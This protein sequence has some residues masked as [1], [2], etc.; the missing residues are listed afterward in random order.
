[1]PDFVTAAL[2]SSSCWLI[3]ITLLVCAQAPLA[4][5]APPATFTADVSRSTSDKVTVDFTLVPIRHSN[6]EVRLVQSD[7]SL[8]PHT[9]LAPRTYLG[10]VRG[11]PGA[12]ACGWLRPDGTLL[13]RVA[14][15]DGNEWS[16]T[17]G[18][19]SVRGPTS[20]W[21]A[22][23]TTVVPA[24]G[25]GGI[26]YAAET[27]VDLPYRQLVASGGTPDLAVGMAEYAVMSANYLFLRDAAIL[28]RVGRVVIR[29]AE[30]NDPY[31]AASSVTTTTLLNEVKNQ[32]NNVL[33]A[34][35]GH[36]V[37]L[38]ARPSVNGGLAWVG[39]IGNSSNRY[40]S[41]N[42]SSI[43]D[44]SVVWRHEVGHNWGSNHYEGGGRPEGPTIMSD[45]SL[46]RFSSS[47]LEKMIAHRNARLSFLESTSDYPFPLPP[48]ANMDRAMFAPEGGTSIDVL[49]NDSDSNGDAISLL[50]F[51]AECSRGGVITRLVGAGPDGRDLLHYT[52]DPE[53]QNGTAFFR[54]RISDSTG[55]TGT[56]YVMVRPE[57]DTF[58]PLHH[59]TLD[60]TSGSTAFNASS[61]PSGT[62]VRNPS[63]GV[64]GATAVTGRGVTY[65]GS[66]QSTSIPALN[67]TGNSYT[68]TAWIRRS[69]SQ[70][71][72]APILYTRNSDAS[73]DSYTGLYLSSNQLRVRWNGALFTPSPALSVPDGEWCLVAFSVS[74]SQVLLHLRTAA[75][76]STSTHNTTIASAS[77]SNPLLL[78]RTQPSSGS[79]LYFGG[80]I[81][82]VRNFP[83]ALGAV[84]VGT[85]YSQAAVPPVFAITNPEPNQLVNPE[86]TRFI[87]AATPPSSLLR[88]V[89][90]YDLSSSQSHGTVHA[91]PFALALESLDPGPQLLGARA[92]YGDW[93]YQVEATP[94]P[95]LV[96]EAQRP[97]VTLT[98]SGHPS[99][100]GP[101]TRFVFRRDSSQGTLELPFSL[102]G[103]A[104]RNTDFTLPGNSVV[105]ANGQNE[106]AIQLTPASEPSSPGEKSLTLALTQTA[107]FVIESPSSATVVFADS[108][109]SVASGN[110]SLGSVW[111]NA[112]A[113]PPAGTQG[114]G[115][116]YI[117]M[118][119]HVV[120][121]FDEASNAQAMVS[122]A[123]RITNTGR[124][125][126]AR[127]HATTLQNVSY[128]V[129]RISL[130][131]GGTLRFV[132]SIGSSGHQLAAAIEAVGNATL[133]FSGGAYDQFANLSGPISGTGNLA[134][135]SLS[136]AGSVVANVR[137]FSILSAGNPFSGDWSIEHSPSGDDFAAL[138]AAAV[139][140]LGS[141]GVSVKRRSRLI[142]DH[143]G[144]LDSLAFIR[145][146]GETSSLLLNQP[147]Q[148]PDAALTLTSSSA[149][150]VV[151]NAPSTVGSLAGT[152]GSLRGSGANSLLALRQTQ[153]G[154]FAGSIGQ[155]LRLIK[156]GPAAL[157]LSGPISPSAHLE[158]DAGRLA[159]TGA[160]HAFAS[161]TLRGG[162]LAITRQGATPL[163]SPSLALAQCK[164]TGGG[165]ELAFSSP[166]PLGEWITL[167]SYTG[168]R[169][170]QPEFEF[171]GI[172]D[173]VATLDYGSGENDEIRVRFAEPD[174]LLTVTASPASGGIV[175][176]S[177]SFALGTQAPLSAVANPGWTF[178]GWSGPGISEPLA[179]SSTVLVD[180][181][182]TVT[183]LFRNDSPETVTIQATAAA[184]ITTGQAG[185]FEIS[186][187]G[188]S[189][190]L[191]V[192]FD[193]SG[194]ATPGT[195]YLSLSTTVVIPDGE[196]TASIEVFP[197]PGAPEGVTVSLAILADAVVTPADPAAATVVFTLS[198]GSALVW[199]ISGTPGVQGGD[200]T[201][202]LTATHWTQDAGSTRSAWSN[203]SHA[204]SAAHFT[205]GSGRVTVGHAIQLGAIAVSSTEQSTIGGRPLT[206]AI[207]GSGLLNFGDREG[208]IHTQ[209]AGLIGIQI[210]NPLTGTRGLRI[211][212][213]DA[214]E[215]G[216]VAWISLVGEN[217]SLT[218]GIAI[219]NGLLGIN[220]PLN[221]AH[222][223]I[224]L[225][226]KSGLYGPVNT[227]AAAGS[228]QVTGPSSLT[229]ANPLGLHGVENHLR[230]W[231]GRTLSLTGNI[232]GPGE[233]LKTDGGTLALSGE[234]SHSGGTTV[235]LGQINA[236]S[237]TAFGTGTV[238]FQHSASSATITRANLVNV[239]IPNNFILN[240][241]A[242]TGFRGPLN[243]GA[244]NTLSIVSGT[245]TVQSNVGN[246]GHFSSLDGGVLRLTGTIN[247]SGPQP[248]I[249]SGTIEMATTGGN[250]TQLGQGEG[251]LRLRANN[252]IQPTLR[253]NL[254]ISGA[255]TLDL[256]GFSQ[257]LAELRRHSTPTATVT[258]GAA[259]P[260]VLAIDGAVSH[261]FSGTIQQG[262]GGGGISVVKNGSAT[263]TL[264]GVNSYLGSTRVDGGTLLLNASHAGASGEVTVN[265]GGTLGGTSTVGGAVSVKSGG[266][267][268]PGA[269]GGTLTTN[270]AVTLE[271]GATFAAQ[272]DSSALSATRLSAKAA[273]TLTDATL[274]LTDTAVT[275]DEIPLGTKFNLIDYGANTLTGTFTGLPEGASLSVGTH[276]FTISYVDD[277]KVTLASSPASDPFATWAT[278]AGLDGTDGKEAGFNDDPDSDGI[279]NGIEWILGGDPLSGNSASLIATTATAEG[280][281]MLA[282]TRDEESLGSVTLEVEYSAT[283]ADPWTRVAIGAS[284]SG[285]DAN[286]ATVSI[287][288]APG[289]KVVTV[290]IPA[291]NAPHGKLFARLKASQP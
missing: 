17:G 2:R 142:N 173:K 84:Q 230:V 251:T 271:S 58:E 65:N 76:L 217:S 117:V 167:I 71:N 179:A 30:A 224:T 130:D 161:L 225:R 250:L 116:D 24:G 221:L 288:T 11:H 26:V 69:G 234:N 235:T 144:G 153:D 246:G 129:P 63:V 227:A 261:E 291:S 193:A 43:G 195:H 140:A 184:N 111:S 175:T 103:T 118:G 13:A 276:T 92:A 107:D 147:T 21:P 213:A 177:G 131:A 108:V 12:I 67:L 274:K 47:E 257:T 285:P 66:T 209:D 168:T 256:N 135:Q 216:G 263:W 242:Q 85:L 112:Q 29:M 176:G 91:P 159:L 90:F 36:R 143:S 282:F 151:G 164:H 187:S 239:T 273:V 120:R 96:L 183:A 6:F 40:S 98:A 119:G 269:D 7:G 61:G 260:A 82:D 5:Q 122:R 268:A 162:K 49:V 207:Q 133:Q 165:I 258:N 44:F 186:R 50:S 121:S 240:T 226:G 95:F 60:E 275:P 264:S 166:P 254:A 83:G 22:W 289:P 150:V 286:G 139:N 74:P 154:S 202:D 237:N 180:E 3:A 149:E 14:F 45:N 290:T 222:N 27:G 243:T 171:V 283:L 23:P 156:A 279:P 185:R 236:T 41:N 204:A 155:D 39:V 10:S 280:G 9:P 267:L 169:S 157:T 201:W 128:N 238:A 210:L 134:L 72:G 110:W 132:A 158:L 88:A 78:G 231:G 57:A 101:G 42:S 198:E 182:K 170:G 35:S 80:S 181:A 194:T 212:A 214:P 160:N 8:T 105:F 189:G 259:S 287:D 178:L 266:T 208:L 123:L 20:W 281:L 102:T 136:N 211:R 215:S 138:R 28:H 188:T 205:T 97:L 32:W 125:E 33:P 73:N 16:S 46:P 15:E 229:L 62:H 77:F 145:L 31:E 52:P 206:Y 114:T 54:Y 284:S 137:T 18:N 272:I 220:A 262:S 124:L 75:G 223:A 109:R 113:A 219:D 126:L 233:L 253:L 48:R 196:S 270:A 37:A 265:S 197:Q 86:G 218:G 99:F 248:N 106:I 51:D 163:A 70:I 25:A 93:G 245:V 53:F 190:H 228:T 148:A 1:M 203:T 100:G 174:P 199:D 94:V 115:P 244:G 278:A 141:G 277:G 192:S 4:A 68:F 89:D 19:A 146:E 252:G 247:T 232:S 81:D 87:A 191:P 104:V 56:G 59:W 152:A 127:T 38:V 34:G 200:G 79:P 249:R 241:N 255:G 55:L 64:P 172:T